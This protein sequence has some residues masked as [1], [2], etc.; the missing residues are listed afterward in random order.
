MKDGQHASRGAAAADQLH[1]IL[2]ADSVARG[3]NGRLHLVVG[4]VGAEALKG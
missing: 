4:G 2:T 3:N 1:I